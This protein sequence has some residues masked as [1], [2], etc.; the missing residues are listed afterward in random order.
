[1]RKPEPRWPP[2]R[3]PG[4]TGARPG[5]PAFRDLSPARVAS[6]VDVRL[7]DV[8]LVRLLQLGRAGR[9]HIGTDGPEL[10]SA[11]IQ[12]FLLLGAQLPEVRLQ[13]GAVG[14][15]HLTQRLMRG[16]AN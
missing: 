11:E 5:R 8:T 9:L 4:R 1:M 6:P 12:R 14:Y 15:V 16:A 13:D 7:A 3:P 2:A 10:K